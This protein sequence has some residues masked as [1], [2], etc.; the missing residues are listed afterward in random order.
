MTLGAA[1][2]FAELGISEED[3]FNMPARRLAMLTGLR[4]SFFDDERRADALAKGREEASFVADKGIRLLYFADT[5]VYPRRLAEC[6]D[7]PALL[8]AM[9]AAPQSPHVISVVGTRHSTAYGTEFTRRLIADL[10]EAIPDLMVVSGLAYGIDICAHR[11]ALAAGATTGAVFAHGLNTVYPAE[12]RDDAR[13]MV[14]EGGFV[15]TEYPSYAAVHKGNFLSR[16]RIVAALADATVVIESDIKGG[17]MSTARIA[18]AY[19]RQVMALPG[20]TSDTYSRGCNRLIARREADM[21]TD[22]GDLLDALNWTA[23]PRNSQPELPLLSEEQT[24][25]TAY[26]RQNPDRTVN[27][28]CAAL[29]IPYSRLSGLLFELEMENIIASMPGGRFVVLNPDI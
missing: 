17:A 13:R 9:G 2:H 22:A 14:R 1:R 28:L 23:A 4:E 25:I 15:L 27:E 26:L 18:S 20:R 29:S 24:N 12:H 5:D 19:N 6:D 3:F 8:Y 16:N 21:I 11:A 10:T 7:A